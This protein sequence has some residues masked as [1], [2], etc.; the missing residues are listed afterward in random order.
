[1]RLSKIFKLVI[2]VFA[3]EFAGVIGS[4]FTFP[5]I[6]S[7]YMTLAKPALNP[8]A[9]VFGPVWT[10]LFA[11]MGIAVFLIWSSYSSHSLVA[12]DEQDKTSEEQKKQKTKIALT[13]F[14]VQLALNVLWS[15]IFFGLHNPAGAFVDILLLWLAIFGTIFIFSK[16]SK[17]AAWLLM[18][19]IIWV[20]F[21]AYLNYA[22]WILN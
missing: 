9:W 8:P 14:C 20:S 2:A 7:W 10:I 21:A 18:P 3:C 1:M 6:Q 11:L 16:I 22:S 17:V 4:V 12:A 13:V 19:Y 5:S 15:I